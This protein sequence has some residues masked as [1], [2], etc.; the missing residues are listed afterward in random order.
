[1]ISIL[2]NTLTIKIDSILL[3]C[4][5]FYEKCQCKLYKY[6]CKLF[7]CL[8][9]IFSQKVPIVLRKA[10]T[11]I[12]IMGRRYKRRVYVNRDKYAVEQTLVCTPSIAEWETVEGSDYTQVS[13]QWTIPVVQ[14]TTVQGMR[15]VKHLTFSISNSASNGDHIPLAYTIAFVPEGYGPRNINYP[16]SGQAI[17]MYE[18]NQYV[19]SQGVVDLSAGP[20]R[21]RSPLSRNLNSGD[22]LVLILATPSLQ[23]ST[24]FMV[25]VKYAITL[26]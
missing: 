13:Q 7:K 20:A 21:I 14:S 25:S 19:L 17:S 26:Q 9:K 2:L 11:I 23:N 12:I 22:R 8:L 4:R 5:R 18:P 24:Y 10:I 3:P 1:M 6:S 15:K 16:N